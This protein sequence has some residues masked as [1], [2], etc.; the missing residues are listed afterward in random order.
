MIP[1]T[2]QYSAVCRLFVGKFLDSDMPT[3]T[4]LIGINNN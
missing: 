1:E 4:T 3:V 2:P